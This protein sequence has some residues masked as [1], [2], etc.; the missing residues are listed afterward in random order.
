MQTLLLFTL[1]YF[2]ATTNKRKLHLKI[3]CLLPIFLFSC[4]PVVYKACHSLYCSSL[5]VSWG[6]TR[7]HLSENPCIAEAYLKNFT[8]FPNMKKMSLFRNRFIFS[9]GQRKYSIPMGRFKH[10]TLFEKKIFYFLYFEPEHCSLKKGN[11]YKKIEIVTG[12]YAG[13]SQNQVT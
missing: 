9:V 5:H 13:L 3:T 2:T 12:S 4:S 10:S 8:S 11:H 7:K 6:R 1:L